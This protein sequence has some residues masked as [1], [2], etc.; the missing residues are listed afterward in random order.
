MPQVTPPVSGDPGWNPPPPPLPSYPISKLL[1]LT[2][3]LYV[4]TGVLSLRREHSDSAAAAN[5]WGTLGM[6]T[7]AQNLWASVSSSIK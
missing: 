7:V 6:G 4:L 1:L 2:V 3:T 5:D